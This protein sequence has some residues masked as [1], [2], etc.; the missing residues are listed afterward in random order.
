M[1]F[2]ELL[3]KIGDNSIPLRRTSLRSLFLSA[4]LLVPPAPLLADTVYTYTGQDYLWNRTPGSFTLSESVSGS[5]TV[6]TPLAPDLA[7]GPITPLAFSFSD[8]ADAFD[9][10]TPSYTLEDIYLSTDST[11]A[12]DA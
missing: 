9:N 10:T 5:F 1:P 8:G 6:S 4:L 2:D 11:G 12:I 7:Y 3:G